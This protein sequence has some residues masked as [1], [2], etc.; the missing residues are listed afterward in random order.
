MARASPQVPIRRR[1]FAP[2]SEERFRAAME[3]MLDGFAILSAVR[4]EEGRIRDFRWEYINEA[5]CQLNH[6]T[7]G[8]MLG[9]SLLELLPGHREALFDHWVRVVESGA[10]LDLTEV[11]RSD[12]YGGGRA[13]TRAFDVRA[14]KLEDG[15]A[16]TW[17]DVTERLREEQALRASEARFQAIFEHSPEGLLL[18]SPDGQIHAANPA[19]CALLGSTEAEICAMGREGVVDLQDPRLAQALEERARTGFFKTE[20]RLKR[21]DGTLFPAEAASSVF[22]D[23]DGQTRTVIQFRDLAPQKALEAQNLLLASIIASTED[24]I[25]S[26]SLDGT[27]LSWNRGAEK[28][29]GF[30]EPEVLGH[31]FLGS[32]PPGRR[33][34]FQSLMV[35]ARKGEH[36]LDYGFERLHKGGAL[37]QVAIDL[38]PLRTAEGEIIGTADIVRDIAV[39]RSAEEERER[40]IAELKEAL[41]QVRTLRG[42]VPICASCKKIRDDAGYWTQV[43]K[44]VQDHTH[45]MFSHGMC[46]DCARIYYPDFAPEESP[47]GGA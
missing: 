43:E 6:R 40:L 24:A 33:E 5:G 36:I 14:V 4:D 12:V 21:K 18:T 27:V 35:R 32:I 31:P 44:F 11:E 13:L 23:A 29:Y 34:E 16:A 41:A 19:A 38:S 45:A 25:V 10:P 28:L 15:F 47:P 1:T 46:P 42:L 3:A 39:R 8:E 9:H 22:A 26:R 20:L 30:Q 17:R 37:L 7:R 2:R